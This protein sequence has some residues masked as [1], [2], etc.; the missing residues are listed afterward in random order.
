MAAQQLLGILARYKPSDPDTNRHCDGH[1]LRTLC[2]MSALREIDFRHPSALVGLSA[3]M[4]MEV[5]ADRFVMTMLGVESQEDADNML[6]RPGPAHADLAPVIFT[7]PSMASNYRLVGK[8]GSEATWQKLRRGA[9]SQRVHE[10]FLSR[11]AVTYHDHWK[12]AEDSAISA[13][14]ERFVTTQLSGLCQQT[15]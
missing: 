10:A 9:E 6:L 2:I 3:A 12:S 1:N 13:M 7:T 14:A 11:A 4:S 5:V 15:D 8:F